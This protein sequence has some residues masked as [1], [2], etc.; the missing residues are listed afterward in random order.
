MNDLGSALILH[1]IG[2]PRICIPP[3]LRL[4]DSHSPALSLKGPWLSRSGR[5]SIS[6]TEVLG[7]ETAVSNV[8]THP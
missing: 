1:Y 8:Q 7:G 4:L 2:V 3:R 6:F 5:L